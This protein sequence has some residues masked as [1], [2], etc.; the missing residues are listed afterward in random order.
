MQAAELDMQGLNATA[1]G[2]K[3]NMTRVE[4]KR[5]L[6]DWRVSLS[7]DQASR[8]MARDLLNKMGAHYD[9]LIKKSDDLLEETDTLGL[10]HQVVAQKNAAI[11][12]IA[13]LESKRLDAFQRAGLLESAELGDEIAQWEE[14]KAMIL[15]I[16]RDLC[17]ACRAKVGNRIA[18][19]NGDTVPEEHDTID[20]EVIG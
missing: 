16:L 11:K 5:L 2:K 8:D 12:L 6:E 4:V 18:K 7:E 19:L 1:I 20:V 14:E 10:S 9:V 3:L 17:P 13:E 15:E